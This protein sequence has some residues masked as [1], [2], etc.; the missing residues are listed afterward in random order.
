MTHEQDLPITTYSAQPGQPGVLLIT[1]VGPDRTV[2]TELRIPDV[3][4]QVSPVVP[5]YP[6]ELPVGSATSFRFE[7]ARAFTEDEFREFALRVAARQAEPDGL[8]GAMQ[9]FLLPY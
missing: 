6:G 4:L 9:K 7:C 8:L 3:V 5:V 2:T 1:L